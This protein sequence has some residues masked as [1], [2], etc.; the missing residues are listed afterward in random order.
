MP[1]NIRLKTTSKA[2]LKKRTEKIF[3]ERVFEGPKSN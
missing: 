2:S 1:F 3:L